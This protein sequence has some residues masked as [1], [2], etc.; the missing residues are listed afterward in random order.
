MESPNDL[1]VNL[2]FSTLHIVFIGSIN[3]NME[4][5]DVEVVEVAKHAIE[6]HFALKNQLKGLKKQCAVWKPHS[7]NSVI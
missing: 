6:E 3:N 5:E 1:I 2:V 4:G 7:C